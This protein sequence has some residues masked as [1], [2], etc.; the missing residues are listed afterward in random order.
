[1]TKAIRTKSQVEGFITPSPEMSCIEYFTKEA[2]GQVAP[3]VVR[4]GA[5]RWRLLPVRWWLRPVACGSGTAGLAVDYYKWALYFHIER[6]KFLL[7]VRKP[8]QAFELRS[9]RTPVR[10]GVL[11]CARRAMQG[12]AYV[13]WVNLGMAKNTYAVSLVR[14]L[15]VIWDEFVAESKHRVGSCS[16]LSRQRFQKSGRR[17]PR[18]P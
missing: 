10:T 12:G 9:P 16:T 1:M 14:A 3:V 6:A 18:R 7:R 5:V 17:S 2:G 8:F 11:F 15:H 4:S 13:G